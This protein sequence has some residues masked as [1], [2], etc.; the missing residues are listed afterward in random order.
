M[1]L[2]I[3]ETLLAHVSKQNFLTLEWLFPVYLSVGVSLQIQK[4]RN[5]IAKPFKQNFF[6]HCVVTNLPKLAGPLEWTHSY[7][8]LTYHLLNWGSL[9]NRLYGPRKNEE[10]VKLSKDIHGV[11][12]MQRFSFPHITIHQCFSGVFPFQQY[13]VICHFKWPFIKQ[14]YCL[15]LYLEIACFSTQRQ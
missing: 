2:L 13:K 9:Q 12:V 8:K 6:S 10:G 5:F 3:A 14:L 7:E 4:E 11:V 15:K 1:H